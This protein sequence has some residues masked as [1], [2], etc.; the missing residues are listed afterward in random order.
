MTRRIASP[1]PAK[2]LYQRVRGT[3]KP[4][5]DAAYPNG[6]AAA[7]F[8]RTLL[9]SASSALSSSSRSMPGPLPVSPAAERIAVS[10]CSAT[11]ALS[12]R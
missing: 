11:A 7:E 3:G 9:H 6:R 10:I 4:A 2:L 12:L 1:R 8:R 5:R